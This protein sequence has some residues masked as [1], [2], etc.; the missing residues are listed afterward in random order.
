[1]FVNSINY[2]ILELLELEG[3][4]KATLCQPPQ[5][6]PLKLY[7]IPFAAAQEGDFGDALPR[8]PL[9]AASLTRAM[10]TSPAPRDSE[11][12]LAFAATFDC[13]DSNEGLL[14]SS[15]YSAGQ[16]LQNTSTFS[17]GCQCP[18][19]SSLSWRALW[20]L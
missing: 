6:L 14:I 15:N 16:H 4:L 12:N 3:T 5:H 1:M 17:R 19:V 8:L 10:G 2:K 18:G 7:K 20:A 9:W 11:E 13:L